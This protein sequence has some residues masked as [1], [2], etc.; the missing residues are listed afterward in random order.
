MLRLGPQ[1]TNKESRHLTTVPV[2]QWHYGL[3]SDFLHSENEAG[4]WSVTEKNIT[5]IL[6]KGKVQL[7]INYTD[8]SNTTKLSNIDVPPSALAKGSCS[9]PNEQY[10]ILSWQPI[11]NS[12]K[13]HGLNNTLTFV[14]S[15]NETSKNYSD[16][17]SGIIPA[18]KFAII[19]VATVIHKNEQ[20]FPNSTN[21]GDPVVIDQEGLAVFPT[22]LKHSFACDAV[23]SIGSPNDQ[24][25]VLLQD[26][27]M[28]SFR[29]LPKG[30]QED[31]DFSPAEHCSADEISTGHVV[32]IVLIC[33]VVLVLIA[34]AIAAVYHMEYVTKWLGKRRARTTEHGYQNM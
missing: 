1:V 21:P 19:K 30:R 26:S 5:C 6:L 27:Q 18:G 3:K 33:V 22:T 23:I 16:D 29:V 17:D 13:P 12:S 8:T 34:I 4:T 28:E 24:L 10:I 25:A 20:T 2:P 15:A 9:E 31:L 7:T 11:S 32:I 14:F